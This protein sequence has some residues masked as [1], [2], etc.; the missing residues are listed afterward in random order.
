MGLAATLEELAATEGK[1]FYSGNLADK[2]A[3]HAE[4][5]GGALTVADLSAHRTEWVSP[6][7]LEYRGFCLHELP[8][9][10]QGLA[11]LSALGLLAQRPLGDYPAD[12]ADAVHLQIEAMKLALVDAKRFVAEPASMYTPQEALLDPDYLTSRS[13]LIDMGHAGEHDHGQPAGGETV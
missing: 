9:N 8:P 3:S 1:S 11:A 6:I 2:I 10:G 4:A 12:G 7:S 5:T 13:G